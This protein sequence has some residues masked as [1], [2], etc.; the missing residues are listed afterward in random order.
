MHYSSHQTG[1]KKAFW[2]WKIA[3]YL[4][5]INV[6]SKKYLNTECISSLIGQLLLLMRYSKFLNFF[7]LSMFMSLSIIWIS[8]MSAKHN[9]L[10][11][12]LNH[13]YEIILSIFSKPLKICYSSQS[14]KYKDFKLEIW[15]WWT[16]NTIYGH[17]CTLIW[18]IGTAQDRT[19]L[20]RLPLFKDNTVLPLQ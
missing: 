2:N 18:N 13:F 7:S 20:G 10:R 17:G 12:C 9:S 1:M 8:L 4:T 19:K 3:I 14:G 5:K 11:L 16:D 15:V 6:Y